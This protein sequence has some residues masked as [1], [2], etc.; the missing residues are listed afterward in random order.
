MYGVRLAADLASER[1]I[2]EPVEMGY[3]VFRPAQN[4]DVEIII[5]IL[6]SSSI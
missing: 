6:N 5:S 3:F 1:G 2:K 4:I